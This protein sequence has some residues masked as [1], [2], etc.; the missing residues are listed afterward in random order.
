[1]LLDLNESI[2]LCYKQER[3]DKNVIIVILNKTVIYQNMLFN[4]VKVLFIT[5]TQCEY[6][7][8]V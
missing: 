2:N 7:H 3:Q 4:G 1:M 6:N 8:R 5:P